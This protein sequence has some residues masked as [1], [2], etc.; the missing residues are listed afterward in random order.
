MKDDLKEN[1]ARL[2]DASAPHV[3][4]I[5]ETRE[6]D[7]P[8]FNVFDALGV[9]RKEVIQSRFLA[10]L[11][12]PREHH[13][14]GT[15]FLKAFLD[16]LE[17]QMGNMESARVE[18]ERS[19]GEG[20]GRMDI[21]IDCKPWLIVIEVKIDAGEG[22]EQLSRYWKWLKQQR[23]YDED[24]KRLIFL[25][26]TGHESVTV[27][28]GVSRSFS[29]SG[30]AK[31]FDTLLKS[32]SISHPAVL[33]VLNQYVS[34]CRSIGGVNM[35]TQDMELHELLTKNLRVAL[36][37]E[38]QTAL[39]RKI[40]A[41]NFSEAVATI[42]QNK[43]DESPEIRGK[44]QSSYEWTDYDEGFSRIRIHT[45]GH[46]IKANYSLLADHVF[47]LRTDISRFGWYRPASLKSGERQET[48]P[49][50]KKMAGESDY[51]WVASNNLHDEKIGYVHTNK[52]HI[53]AC[54]EDNQSED[55]PLATEMANAMWQLFTTYRSDI[56]ALPSFQ[57][58]AL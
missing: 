49:L 29:Y 53:L 16:M 1:I 34:I 17:I 55:H 41:K 43:I 31:A 14:Q 26:P 9:I 18:A 54:W 33:A 4:R 25:T 57:Q 19:A 27:E 47:S 10:Y 7:A 8:Y 48:D 52:E 3:N 21:V 6:K 42:I 23:G 28:D 51:W 13:N 45:V 22:E 32:Q 38:Q 20:L 30:L 39:S 35:A 44:W 5:E 2:L 36:E 15:K 46:K 12:S 58:A 40:I 50:T 11:L 37:I 24:K 56:E